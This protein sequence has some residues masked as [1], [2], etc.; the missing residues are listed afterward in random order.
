MFQAVRHQLLT[1]EAWVQSQN[2]RI[3]AEQYKTKFAAST[4]VLTGQYHATSAPL[5][6]F[7]CDQRKS[8]NAVCLM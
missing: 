7:I 6:Y 1:A 4:L 3:C 8:G 5:S 2:S